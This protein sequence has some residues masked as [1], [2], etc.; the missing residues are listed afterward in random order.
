MSSIKQKHCKC[1]CDKYPT[2]G[3][4]GYNSSCVLEEE[5]QEFTRHKVS[6]RK[7]AN[8][9]NLTTAIHKAQLKVGKPRIA[10]KHPTKPIAKH[11]KKMLTELKIYRVLRKDYLKDHPICEAELEGCKKKSIEIHHTASR[12]L[13]LNNVDTWIAVCRWCH[14][15]IHLNSKSAREKGLLIR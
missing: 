14:D 10:L 8:L 9:R 2:T 4:K 6:L 12:G 1:G 15:E 5:R 7:A 3:F 13:N 11:S